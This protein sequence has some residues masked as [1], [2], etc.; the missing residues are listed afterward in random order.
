MSDDPFA[1]PQDTSEQILAAT[2]RALRD[3]GYDELTISAIG[4]EFEKSP[5]LV[6]RHYDS[7]DELVLEC[8]AYLLERFEREVTSESITDPRGRLED[9]LEWGV[10][11]D[12]SDRLAFVAMIVELRSLAVHDEAYREHFTRS[13][14]V[15]VAYLTDVIEAGI[16]SGDF[17]ECDPEQVARTL[18]T[19]LSGAIVH[20]STTERDWLEDVAAELDTY[21]E[22]R[23]DARE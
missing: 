23:L 18:V 11:G 22:T 4:E 12:S 3:R 1:D 15:F 17:R 9:F 8:L 2:Y 19:T 21:V 6:Y 5:S 16:E 10:R 14:D 7:K 20:Y 13:D